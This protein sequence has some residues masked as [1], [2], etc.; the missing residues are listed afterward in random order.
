MGLLSD[1]SVNA[2]ITREIIEKIGDFP[3]QVVASEKTNESLLG[4]Q[5]FC[6]IIGPGAIL[7]DDACRMVL[8]S[9]SPEVNYPFH[10]H[11]AEEVYYELSGTALWVLTTNLLKYRAQV[12]S[13]TIC[14]A[15]HML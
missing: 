15:N 8:Y 2:P 5:A 12:I 9:Q 10:T 6:N 7:E 4:K 3:W 13:F 11:N 14:L 1:Q